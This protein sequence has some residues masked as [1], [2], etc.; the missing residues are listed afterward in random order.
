MSVSES[1]PIMKGTFLFCY[2]EFF[3]ITFLVFITWYRII[4]VRRL[5]QRSL[6]PRQC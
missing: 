2:D 4:I 5:L 1:L 3:Y 6:P